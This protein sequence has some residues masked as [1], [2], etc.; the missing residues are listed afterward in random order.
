MGSDDA[1]RGLAERLL[2]D[3]VKDMTTRDRKLLQKLAQRHVARD[4]NTEFDQQLTF[5]ERLS[6]RVAEFGGSWTF[7]I[8]FGVVIVA[9]VLL[10]AVVLV[11]WGSPFDAYPFIFLNL[12]LS[13]VAAIQAPVIMMSQNRQADKDRLAAQHDYEVNLKA[14]LEI[15]SLHEKL[16]QMRTGEL[17]TILDRIEGSL[18]QHMAE[19]ELREALT[20]P[21]RADRGEGR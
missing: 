4:I 18:Q 9:W 2:A 15:M 6:D 16:E 3:G 12:V 14:E 10:N 20:R 17:K 7:I 19:D 13:M 11:R 8:G 5:G 21:G 1:I